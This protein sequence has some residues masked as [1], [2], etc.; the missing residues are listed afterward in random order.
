MGAMDKFLNM[1]K[2][3]DVDDEY[4]SDDYY[5]EDEVDEV[6]KKS[7]FKSKE[8][9]DEEDF[10]EEKAKKTS[11]KVTPIRQV[12]RA[13]GSN[14]EV[15]II[16]P[17]SMEDAQEITDTLVANRTVVLNLEGLDVEIGQRIV[18]YTS[19]S[20][21]ALGGKLQKISNYILVVTP[22]SVGISGDFQEILSGTFDVPPISHIVI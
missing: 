16:K 15:C 12:K 9:L 10:E 5:D 8:A 4:D 18:D 7:F 22:A 3:G 21:Y 2:L 20:I 14:M 11:T 19:G 6:P 13:P 1:M 17:T